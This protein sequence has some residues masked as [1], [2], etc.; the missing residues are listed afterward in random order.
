MCGALAALVL[1]AA[2]RDPKPVD[3]TSAAPELIAPA[4]IKDIM[5]SMVDP[6]ADNIFEAVAE[7]ADEQ[8]IRQ[9]AP[10]TPEQ[11]REVRRHAI[12]LLE[13]PNLLVMPGRKTARPGEKSENPDVELQPEQIQQVIDK[14]PA[15]FRTRARALQ[16]AARGAVEAIDRKDAKGLFD[17]AGRIDKACENCHLQ[18]W[19][20]NDKR[21]QEAAREN[22]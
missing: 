5:D 11:W 20:P 10:Q 12:Q 22:P 2:C 4:T 14:D 13:A 3:P 7:V 16:D 19:Y 1:A 15:L 18:Y 8:G 17:A 6:S 21:A 9:E